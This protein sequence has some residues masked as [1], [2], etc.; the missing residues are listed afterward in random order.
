MYRIPKNTGTTSNRAV[1][2]FA[3]ADEYARTGESANGQV[4][5]GIQTIALENASELEIH[6][7][8]FRFTYPPKDMRTA[9]APSFA[10]PG[11]FRANSLPYGAATLNSIL[12]RA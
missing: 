8:R 11:V 4:E 6:G 1:V 5:K 7:K 3:P 10:D 9:L 12:R 2:R